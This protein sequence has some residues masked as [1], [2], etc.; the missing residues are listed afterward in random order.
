MTEWIGI[1]LGVFGSSLLAGIAIG[2]LVRFRV[3]R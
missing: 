1:T 2:K 3:R